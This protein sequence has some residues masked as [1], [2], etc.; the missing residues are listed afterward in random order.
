MTSHV[1]FWSL[2]CRSRFFRP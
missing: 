2:L 1:I